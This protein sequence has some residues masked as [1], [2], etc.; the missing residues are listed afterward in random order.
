MGSPVG[1]EPASVGRVRPACPGHRGAASSPR[2][3]APRDPALPS[4]RRKSKAKPNGKKPAAEEK[5]VYLEPEYTKSRITDFGFKELVVLPRE[6][7]L[8]EWLAS[9]S[10]RAGGGQAGGWAAPGGG[11][12]R[13]RAAGR[14]GHVGCRTRGVFRGSLGV[15]P[16]ARRSLWEGSLA[17]RPAVPGS[18]EGHGPWA[19]GGRTHTCSMTRAH[20]HTL[21]HTHWHTRTHPHWHPRS[22]AHPDTLIDTH[23]RTPRHTHWRTQT[24]S[25]L[26]LDRHRAWDSQDMPHGG[27]GASPSEQQ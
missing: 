18:Q 13:R 11:K 26:P 10:A 2:P 8:N 21:R 24:H 7:D 9:N 5:K 17:V 15:G 16:S 1:A 12:L 14:A 25:P 19:G 27:Q 3:P 4:P 20:T 6:I 23:T 22:L